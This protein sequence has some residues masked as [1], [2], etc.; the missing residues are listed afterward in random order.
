MITGLDRTTLENCSLVFD[1][2]LGVTVH[3]VPADQNGNDL[4]LRLGG[5]LFTV[6]KNWQP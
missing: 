1:A 6:P 2:P 5:A 3:E 4:A